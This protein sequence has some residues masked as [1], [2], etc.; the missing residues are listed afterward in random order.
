ME[1]G[2]SPGTERRASSENSERN[3]ALP[4]QKTVQGPAPEDMGDPHSFSSFIPSFLPSEAISLEGV[5]DPL[6]AG[7][8]LCIFLFVGHLIG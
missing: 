1:A 8:S 2:L 4:S 7:S 3:P 6:F 5:S